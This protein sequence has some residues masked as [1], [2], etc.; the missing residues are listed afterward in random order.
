MELHREPPPPEDLAEVTDDLQRR[1]GI[2]FTLHH[3]PGREPVP[4]R[5][6]APPALARVLH[7]EGSAY[8]LLRADTELDLSRE[9]L[10]QPPGGTARQARL[11][12]PRDCDGQTLR[13]VRAGEL[14]TAATLPAIVPGTFLY[15]P[16]PAGAGAKQ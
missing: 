5:E 1:F 16:P 4:P 10:L 2:T 15:P 6:A 7:R 9:Y 12:D 8:L 13:K 11:T 3:L 14:F